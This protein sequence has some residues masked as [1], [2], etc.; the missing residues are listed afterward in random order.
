[1]LSSTLKAA[2]V[3]LLSV[4]SLPVASAAAEEAGPVTKLPLPRFVSMKASEANV[5]RGPSLSHRID[6]VFKRRDM[7]LRITAEHGHWR[8]VEDRDGMGGWIHYSLLSGARTVLVEQDMLALHARPDPDAPVM[9][10]L[11]LGVVARL[12]DCVPE[13]C[14]LRSGGYKGW[15]PK[16][17]IW[18]VGPNEIRE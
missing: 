9:A 8:R 13:W 5:R 7:P 15:A 17:R 12:G 10:A 1:M 11:E 6:W 16:A 14:E 2:L 18:G 3:A 4:P